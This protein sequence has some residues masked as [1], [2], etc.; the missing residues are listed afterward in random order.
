MTIQLRSGQTPDPST[1]I[2]S[3]RGAVPLSDTVETHF[4]ETLGQITHR[5]YGANTLENQ[6]RI[7]AANASLIGNVNAPR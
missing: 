1:S 5:A 3:G 7:L 6:R 2:A 4:G